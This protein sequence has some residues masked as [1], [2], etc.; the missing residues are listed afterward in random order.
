MK[1]KGVASEM[2]DYVVVSERT[3]LMCKCT[4]NVPI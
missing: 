1:V 2:T 3:Q 4:T